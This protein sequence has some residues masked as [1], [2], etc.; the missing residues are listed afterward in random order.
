MGICES[1]CNVGGSCTVGTVCKD[2]IVNWIVKW[3]VNKGRRARDND[4]TLSRD[5]IWK[6]AAASADVYNRASQGTRKESGS[7]I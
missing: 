5:C 3:I 2:W 7:R 4:S 6:C 1:R